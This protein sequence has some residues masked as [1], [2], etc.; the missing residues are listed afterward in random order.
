MLAWGTAAGRLRRG[1][2]IGA[3]GLACLGAL[4]VLPGAAPAGTFADVSFSD[5][6]LKIVGDIGGT[7]NDRL[8]LRCK[9]GDVLVGLSQRPPNPV[10]CSQVREVVA[11]PGG[12][13]DAVDMSGVTREFGPGGPIKI[14][15]NGGPGSDGLTGATAQHNFLNGGPDSD[16]VEGGDLSDRL[17]GGTGNDLIDGWGGNDVLLGGPGNDSLFGEHGHDKVIGGPGRDL[18]KP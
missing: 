4:L 2:L 9:D 12:G 11:L 6:T 18:E 10:H 14:T 13:G 7:V 15:I 1:T 3:V 5:G 16:R 17:T 8:A